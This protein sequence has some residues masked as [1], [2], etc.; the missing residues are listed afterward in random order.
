MKRKN[1]RH[2]QEGG[3]NVRDYCR[4][5]VHKN[6]KKKNYCVAESSRL[7]FSENNP[8]VWIEFVRLCC[9]VI[10]HVKSNSSSV[11][12]NRK[13]KIDL[14]WILVQMSKVT[15][16]LDGDHRPSLIFRKKKKNWTH[17]WLQ[18]CESDFSLS[19]CL[20]VTVCLVETLWCNVKEQKPRP[21]IKPLLWTR[22]W[23][24]LTVLFSSLLPNRES[25]IVVLL[26]S[27]DKGLKY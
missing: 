27:A 16:F 20:L 9:V 6:R 14:V 22:F 10:S 13:I 7:K 3:V 2:E 1:C 25:D 18:V 12:G 19:G 17:W 11:F 4:I 26:I 5:R 21:L 23:L 15:C 24:S 8:I